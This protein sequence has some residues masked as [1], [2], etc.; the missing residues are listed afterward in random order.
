MWC[1]HKDRY[2]LDE[3]L[4]WL[5]FP[6]YL[7]YIYFVICSI[8]V[9]WESHFNNIVKKKNAVHSSFYSFFLVASILFITYMVITP[10]ATC[11]SVLLSTKGINY[12]FTVVALLSF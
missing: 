4:D 3:P 5:A 7:F 9:S 11:E 6:C 12:T 8:K 1:F 2:S 10:K